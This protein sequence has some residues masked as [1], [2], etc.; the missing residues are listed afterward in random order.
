MIILK[1]IGLGFFGIFVIAWM[2]VMSES[3]SG[4][5]SSEWVNYFAWISWSMYI[6]GKLSLELKKE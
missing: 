4:E 3:V 2:L 1:N 5:P 6:T